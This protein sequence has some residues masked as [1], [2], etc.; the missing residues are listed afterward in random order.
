VTGMRFD[1]YGWLDQAT[2]KPTLNFYPGSAP[3]E[4]IVMH[5]TA[6]YEAGSAISTF[7]NPTSNASAHFIVDV[8]GD[9][10][11][12]VSVRDD[13]WHA[14][15]GE[16]KGR[17]EVNRFAVGIEIVNPGYHRKAADGSYLD[18][19]HE[20][21]PKAKLTPFGGMTE[22]SDPW[23]GSGKV[24]W[25]NFPEKQLAAVQQLTRT[26]LSSY[27]SITDIVGHRDVD[28]VRKIKVDPGPA[29]PMK[30]FTALLTKRPAPAMPKP[31]DYLVKSDLGYVNVRAKPSITADKVDWSPLVNGDRVQ[32]IETRADWFRVRRWRAGKAN[33]G[34]IMARYLTPA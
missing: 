10:T 20:A 1:A 23:V 9:V 16:Y 33:E 22:A 7:L 21:V 2:R 12:M 8:D 26:L 14:G 29:F 6:S 18:W 28:V 5:Y 11:Q 34:W 4:I 25:A 31:V 17:D 19:K 24:H 27:P 15:F 3:P 32:Q 13:A 30:R